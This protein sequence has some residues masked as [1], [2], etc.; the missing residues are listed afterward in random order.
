MNRTDI[1]AFFGRLLS[2]RLDYAPEGN[3]VPEVKRLWLDVLGH[4]SAA[5]VELALRAYLSGP[6]AEKWPQ[7]VKIAEL[8][9]GRRTSSS[10]TEAKGCVWCAGRGH[11]LA[12][13][14]CWNG[15]ALA[16]LTKAVLCDC[17]KGDWIGSEHARSQHP[18]GPP[19]VKTA[20]QVARELEGLRRGT[21]ED[22]NPGAQFVLWWVIEDCRT[23]WAEQRVP[24]E[25]RAA[26]DRQAELLRVAELH[27]A[28]LATKEERIPTGRHA[29]RVIRLKAADDDGRWEQVSA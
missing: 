17:G 29:G 16:E 22:C 11:R 20:G 28:R 7:P 2:Y 27:R 12:R 9:N 26:L 24:D 13:W 1:D 3:G 15:R 23:E 25:L 8:V 21:L 18:S 6:L 19:E 5:D 4:L 10:E 14:V